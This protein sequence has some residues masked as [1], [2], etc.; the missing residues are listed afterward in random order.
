MC[1]YLLATLCYSTDKE[2]KANKPKGTREI[3]DK[4][5]T[6]EQRKGGD[7][8]R[9]RLSTRTLKKKEAPTGNNQEREP[10]DETGAEVTA[11]GV[12]VPTATR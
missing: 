1:L 7:K 8:Q 5:R 10:K 11:T 12:Q 4:I 9:A 3:D 6:K 2:D